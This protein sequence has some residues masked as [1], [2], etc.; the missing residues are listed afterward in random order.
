M[1]DRKPILLA[2]DTITA[3]D[4]KALSEWLLTN[5]RLTKGPLT[6]EFENKWA[7]RMGTKYAVFVNS[8]S[9]ANL[10][11][12]AA[13]IADNALKNKKV[14]V[15]ALS[16]VTDISP[17]IQFGLEPILV[18]CNMDDL[19]VDID[20][21]ERIF[22]SEEPSCLILVP[23]L[24]MV[25][26]MDRIAELCKKHKVILLVDNCEGQGSH[27]WDDLGKVYISGKHLEQYG[28]MASC[29]TYFGH[30]LSTIE[31]GMITTDDFDLYELLKMLRS[32]GWDRDIDE[33]TSSKLRAKHG[34]SEFNALYTF[35]HPAFNV[36][37]TDLQA[38]IGIRQ[39]DRLTEVA[40]ARNYNFSLYNRLLVNDY[41]KPKQKE[42]DFVSNLGYP[43]IHPMREAI[44]TDLR[45]NNVEVRPLI[46]GSMGQQPF[47]VQRY[48][49]Q[50][51]PNVDRVDKYGFYVP[52]H[53]YLSEA[54]I[55]FICGIINKYTN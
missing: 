17:V 48:G 11:M 31:G 35:Y 44:V 54:D 26:E 5:P 50:T 47:F 27:V 30:I 3:D 4:V 15:P 12:F 39:L 10:L 7:I 38:F 23:V 40:T 13:M 6:T 45:N 25:P 41:W 43:V 42:I 33:D 34:V 18:D 46:S 37:S 28:L 51:W 8:G 24:G 32:H 19:S 49:K 53:P 14:V 21:L 29:S 9:S 52:N 16:W 1:E 20:H 22:T 36:R 55:E 2:E